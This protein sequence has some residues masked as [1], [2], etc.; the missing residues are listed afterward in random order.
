MSSSEELHVPDV[1]RQGFKKFMNLEVLG[2][3]GVLVPRAE[4]ELL[5]HT[6]IRIM[7]GLILSRSQQEKEPLRVIDM[8][9]GAGN[10][11]CC[12]ARYVPLAKVWASDL[13]DAAVTLAKKNVLHLNV[14]DSVRVFQG[15][16]FSAL[17]DSGLEGL[18][19]VIVCNPPYISSGKLENERST[20]LESEPRS[21]FDGGPYGLKI[22]QRVSSEAPRWL[23]PGGYLLLEV[24]LGQEKQ[25]EIILKRT[26]LYQK[27]EFVRDEFGDARVVVA[28][29]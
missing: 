12:M 19:D 20:L 2:E 29:T 1:L 21:A 14:S 17:P 5:A 26:K 11:A 13:T 25:M 6:A 10:L 28:K 22:H 15:D 3:A 27:V 7:N 23:K 18:I 8:C 24:G 4:T 9:C 16:L